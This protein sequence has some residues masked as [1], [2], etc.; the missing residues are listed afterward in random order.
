MTRTVGA[1]L[2]AGPIWWI[3]LRIF[4]VWSGAQRILANPK[5]QSKKFIA[6]FSEVEPL[7][8]MI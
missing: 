5:Y 4:F 8:R 7:S 6:V 3:S 1:C 2:V